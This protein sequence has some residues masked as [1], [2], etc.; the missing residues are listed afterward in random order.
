MFVL[1]FIV[2]KLSLLTDL[3]PTLLEEAE[4]VKRFKNHDLKLLYEL[5]EKCCHTV[6]I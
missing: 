5:G 3:V 2:E 6:G 1:S 4:R